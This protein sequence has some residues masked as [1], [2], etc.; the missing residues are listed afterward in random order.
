MNTAYDLWKAFFAYMKQ[1]VVIEVACSIEVGGD[2]PPSLMEGS[3]LVNN[4]K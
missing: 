2:N 3:D 4:C 1:P